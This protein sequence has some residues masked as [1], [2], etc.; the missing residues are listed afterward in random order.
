MRS[1][2]E[3]QFRQVERGAVEAIGGGLDAGRRA[4]DA[5]QEAVFAA[6]YD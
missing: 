6:L 3:H 5:A 1:T 4:R 2:E